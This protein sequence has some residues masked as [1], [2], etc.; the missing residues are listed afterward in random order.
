MQGLE[1]IPGTKKNSNFEAESKSLNFPEYAR[2]CNRS[3]S[4]GA[5]ITGVY[6]HTQSVLILG[7][8]GHFPTTKNLAPKVKYSVAD[9]L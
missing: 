7:C 9:K 5:G 6:N 2:I 8:T 3:T 1:F 4:L